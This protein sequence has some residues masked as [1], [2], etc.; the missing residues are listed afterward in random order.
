MKYGSGQ[1]FLVGGEIIGPVY[2]S[3]VNFWARG[4]IFDSECVLNYVFY[5]LRKSC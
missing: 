5:D 3:S 1:N 2:G 4:K